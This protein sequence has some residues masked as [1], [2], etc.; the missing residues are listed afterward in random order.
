MA[1]KKKSLVWN[2]FDLINNEGSGQQK[3]QCSLCS[4]PLV[5]SGGSTSS[6]LKHLTAKHP[7]AIAKYK[8]SASGSREMTQTSVGDFFKREDFRPCSSQRKGE[9]TELLCEIIYQDLRPISMF[10][11][12]SFRKLLSFVEP[13]YCVP[14][15][16][17]LRKN[18]VR[19]YDV[20]REEVR[21]EL[22][23][24]QVLSFT[25]DHWTSAVNDAYLAVT[26]HGMTSDWQMKC[27]NL[28]TKITTERHT[29]ENIAKDLKAV[30]EEWGIEEIFSIVH[31]NAANM[32]LAMTKMDS[33]SIPCFAHTIQLAI[34]AGLKTR[35]VSNMIAN[36]RSL[37]GFFCKSNPAWIF[38]QEKQ[39]EKDPATSPLKPMQD[40]VTCWNS[41]HTM[42]KRLLQLKETIL[43]ATEDPVLGADQRR[44]QAKNLRDDEWYLAKEL[45]NILEPLAQATEV[46]SGEQY[47]SISITYPILNGLMEKLATSDED[48]PAL[49]S[50][51]AVVLEQ[52]KNRFGYA[53]DT[54]GENIAVI[55]SALDPRFK[56]LG[57]LPAQTRENAYSA[58]E[59]LMGK[60][61][62]TV[63]DTGGEEQ[64]A[65]PKKRRTAFENLLG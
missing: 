14:S 27:F 13:N 16:A 4:L 26:A 49:S 33:H 51:K 25:T 31:D 53:A 60:Y 65:Q 23:K 39:Q 57:Y 58:I 2:Y 35:T 30:A 43:Q 1:S 19:L 62:P 32:T 15:N 45:T 36:A 20:K 29:G 18:L 5:F 12:H 34:N 46:W 21:G 28:G 52:L 6:L 3:A 10:G 56:E 37:A 24:C 61:N 63:D 17:T 7:K 38:L 64:V 42:L 40:V 59:H 50:F 55:A 11:S 44:Y 8:D 54:L 41:T 48:L 22:F 9:I 47:V